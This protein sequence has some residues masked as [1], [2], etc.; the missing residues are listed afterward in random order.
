MRPYKIPLGDAQYTTSGRK[1]RSDMASC[2]QPRNS[3]A[4]LRPE[5]LK[6]IA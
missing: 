6:A 1:R 5:L 3:R 4:E 2:T